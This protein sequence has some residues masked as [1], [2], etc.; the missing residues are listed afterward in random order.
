MPK[1]G[2]DG[3]NKKCGRLSHNCC[4]KLMKNVIFNQ[5]ET[6]ICCSDVEVEGVT[7]DHENTSVSEIVSDDVTN[8]TDKITIKYLDELIKQKDLII[9][10]Q[11]IAINALQEQIKLL[12]HKNPEQEAEKNGKQSLPINNKSHST[13]TATNSKISKDKQPISKQQ[14]SRAMLNVESERICQNIVGLGNAGADPKPAQKRS[15][16]NILTGSGL[17]TSGC[18]FKAADLVPNLIN[19]PRY[20]H[21][22]HFEPQTDEIELFNYLKGFAANV[23]V[24]K[25]NARQPEM[26]ASFKISVPEN[27]S[28]KI[29][30]AEIWPDKVVVNRFLFPRRH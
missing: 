23:K 28:E 5:D 14:V 9:R 24:E 19:K 11:D 7:L 27:E 30:N 25:L 22:T 26:Y 8:S 12:K 15:G 17:S 21:A 2:A 6:V 20:Y 13:V 29:L 10:N 18:P 16:R 1:M 3:L 4:L